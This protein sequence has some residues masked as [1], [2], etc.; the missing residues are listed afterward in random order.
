[1]KL[2]ANLSFLFPELS[3][4]DR[5]RAASSCGFQ[6]VEFLFP[7][8]NPAE[9]IKGWLLETGLDQVLFN[10]P[11]GDWKNGERGIAALPGREDE[12]QQSFQLALSYAA[13]LNCPRIHV[14]A[15]NVPAGYGAHDCYA[16]LARNLQ[17]AAPIAARNN[18]TLLLEPLNPE[19][20]PG[21]LYSRTSEVTD[22][23]D[24]LGQPNI[25][26]Q[27]DLYHREKVEGN[28][29]GAIEDFRD[30]IGHI[31]IAGVPGRHEPDQGSLDLAGVFQ[32]LRELNYQD[33][34][35]C[36]YHPGGATQSGL[37]W[38]QQFLDQ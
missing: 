26:L 1:M 20:M 32:T 37:A 3:F 31:Q 36:E 8:G 6:G 16:V 11:P 23:I 22:L 12:F 19:D 21:Y 7:Y 14:M 15:G 24:R 2:S 5:F 10:A 13:S 17:W 34:V 30:Y 29:V 35:G 28:A 33:W 9:E 38:A 25:K 27:L 18:I 4:Q